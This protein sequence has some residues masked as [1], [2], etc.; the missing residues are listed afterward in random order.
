[1]KKWNLIVDVALCENCN[2]CAL[3]VKD[4]HVDNSFPGYAAP[5]P[6]HG[7]EWIE[8]KRQMR[9]AA[10]M[11]DVAYLPR[12]CNHCDAAP[13]VAAANGEAIYKRAD[14]IVII[15]PEKAKG[16]RDL[17]D[18]C[19]YG[20]IWWNEV[21]DLPQKWIFDAHLLDQ[22]WAKPRCVQVCPT[23]ALQSAHVTDEEIQAIAQRENLQVLKPE[24]RTLPRVYYRNL[25]RF[26]KCFVGGSVTAGRDGVVDCV[27]GAKVTLLSGDRS[28]ADTET[29]AFGDFK[30]D[31]LDPD[32]GLHE[33]RIAHP[34]LQG[35]TASVNL[36]GKS[37]YLG[38]I[39]LHPLG[40]QAT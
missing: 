40:V 31:G 1:M 14:G 2:N 18:S 10:P 12:T 8:I 23:G 37:V 13:C 35:A 16:R 11:V 21:L 29:D 7:H 38:E 9:G 39:R 6:R 15:D 4:E 5:Q 24:L 26:D 3:A 20:A 28:T 32:S 19:P 22:G 17:V 25:H 36:Q 30:F 33:V 27:R 34:Q